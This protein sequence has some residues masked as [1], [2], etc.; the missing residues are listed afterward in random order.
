MLRRATDDRPR[1]ITGLGLRDSAPTY[2]DP[3]GVPSGGDWALERM[4]ALFLEGTE[5][6]DVDGCRF[7]RLDGNAIM[8]SGY[9]RRATVQNSH[10]AW[11][12]DTAGRGSASREC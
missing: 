3:H 10:F 7:E 4:G 1:P 12:G 9:H 5:D 11:T 8:L 2:M 6:L